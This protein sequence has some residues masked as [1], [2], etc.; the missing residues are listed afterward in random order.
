MDS[1][2]GGYISYFLRPV[3]SLTFHVGMPTSPEVHNGN[4]VWISF[5]A[6]LQWWRWRGCQ[7]KIFEGWLHSMVWW[8]QIYILRIYFLPMGCI[9]MFGEC[10]WICCPT[11]KQANLRDV[12]HVE[13]SFR[14]QWCFDL[15][16]FQRESRW[17]WAEDPGWFFSAISKIQ[18]VGEIQWLNPCRWVT[19]FD[20]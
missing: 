17:D 5:K 10:F 8:F 7:L 11:T 15:C 4:D 3:F 2:P 14:F 6:A 13:T 12:E 18:Q 19:F 16:F 9:T 1:F 20:I